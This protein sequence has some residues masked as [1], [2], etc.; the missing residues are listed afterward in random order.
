M[1]HELSF[2]AAQPPLVYMY[3]YELVGIG[4]E[5]QDRAN[6]SKQKG[7]CKEYK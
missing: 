3:V 2:C 5:C 6:G 7:H 1:E 4:G